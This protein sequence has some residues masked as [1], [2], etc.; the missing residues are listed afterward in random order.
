M[1]EE[2]FEIIDEMSIEEIESNKKQFND[3][4]TKVCKENEIDQ[5]DIDQGINCVEDTIMT[6]IDKINNGEYSGIDKLIDGCYDLLYRDICT[7]IDDDIYDMYY[8]HIK[9]SLVAYRLKMKYKKH[10]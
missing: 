5:D 8:H 3:F 6:V 2:I 9:Y 4:F 1:L 10:K 7:D